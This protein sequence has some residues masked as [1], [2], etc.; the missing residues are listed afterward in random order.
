MCWVLG[1]ALPF[2][3]GVRGAWERPNLICVRRLRAPSELPDNKSMFQR[4]PGDSQLEKQSGLLV[5]TSFRR[6]QGFTPRVFTCLGRGMTQSHLFL[7]VCGRGR[8]EPREFLRVLGEGTAKPLCF[9]MFLA[10]AVP[11]TMSFYVFEASAAL[12]RK[13]LRK[14]LYPA[15]HAADL[16]T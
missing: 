8:A 11:T 13:N 10:L 12:G 7:R 16:A 1:N 3:Y 2:F 4:A 5:F 6:G 9:Y 14:F 15:G